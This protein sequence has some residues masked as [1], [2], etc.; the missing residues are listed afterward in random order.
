MYTVIYDALLYL[1]HSTYTDVT[2]MQQKCETALSFTM[3][4]VHH[5]RVCVCARMYNGVCVCLLSWVL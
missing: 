3:C 5:P 4:V 1:R 2:Q